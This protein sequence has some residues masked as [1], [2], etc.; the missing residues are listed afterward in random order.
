M[1]SFNIAINKTL[2]HEGVGPVMDSNGYVAKYGINA[3]YNPDVDVKNL[4]KEKAIAIYKERYWHPLF[5]KITNQEL[6]NQLFDWRVTSGGSAIKGLQ[7]LLNS[8]GSKLKVDGAYGP[9]TANELSKYNSNIVLERFKIIR[10]SFYDALY[11]NKPKTYTYNMYASWI[12]RITGERLKSAPA[13]VKKKITSFSLLK[14]ILFVAVGYGFY[15]WYK[16]RQ[17]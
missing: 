4:T 17:N 14:P 9:N 5:D 7:N 2:A 10:K 15:H 3:Q 1:A 11:K 8:M 12:Y 13:D 16:L 6:A